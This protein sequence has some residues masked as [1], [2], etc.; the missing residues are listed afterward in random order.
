MKA[1]IILFKCAGIVQIV[2]SGLL[3]LLGLILLLARTLLNIVIDAAFVEFQEEIKTMGENGVAEL[4]ETMK[5][6]A[7]CSKEEFSAYLLKWTLIFAAVMLIIAIIGIVFGVLFIKFSKKY[8]YVFAGRKKRK[9]L[10]GIL[11]VVFCGIGIPTILVVIALSL[12][13]KNK[14]AEV[15]T[16]GEGS[17]NEN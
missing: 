3:A 13:D 7:E 14:K 8:E 16:I 10:F 11:S 17:Q 5:F 2:L 15:N 6:L 1:K 4:D 12:P 9:I